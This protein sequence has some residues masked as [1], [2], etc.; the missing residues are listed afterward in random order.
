MKIQCQ[1]CESKFGIPP[2]FYGKRI[3]CPKCKG[4]IS[5]PQPTTPEAAKPSSPAPDH[6]LSTAKQ[7]ADAVAGAQNR[8]AENATG[9]DSPT[10]IT[11]ASKKIKIPCG[12][13]SASLNVPPKLLGKRVACP[14]CKQPVD[15]VAPLD[16]KPA[17]DS[18]PPIESSATA[19]NRAND[20][21]PTGEQEDAAPLQPA[22]RPATEGADS[23]N[24]NEESRQQETDQAAPA[25]RRSE[26]PSGFVRKIMP[27]ISGMIVGVLALLLLFFLYLNFSGVP[28][29]TTA[30]N[31]PESQTN[32]KTSELNPTP[33]T[34]DSNAE[35]PDKAAKQKA[36]VAIAEVQSRKA[37]VPSLK[38]FTGETESVASKIK[39]LGFNLTAKSEYLE[40]SQFNGLPAPMH[41]RGKVFVSAKPSTNISVDDSEDR[42]SFFPQESYASALRLPEGIFLAPIDS[43]QFADFVSV[44]DGKVRYDVEHSRILRRGDFKA[45]SSP[46]RPDF[47]RVIADNKGQL[48]AQTKGVTLIWIDRNAEIHLL[49]NLDAVGYDEASTDVNFEIPN[50]STGGI[51]VDQAG[52]I[53][54]LVAKVENGI[55]TVTQISKLILNLRDSGE[56]V[57]D[58][59]NAPFSDD[60]AGKLSE[61]S[62]CLVQLICKRHHQGTHAAF[63][64]HMEV[65]QGTDRTSRQ[66][67]DD[68]YDINF[69]QS[70]R[71]DHFSIHEGK[72][73][74]LPGFLGLAGMTCIVDFPQDANKTQWRVERRLTL[75]PPGNERDLIRDISDTNELNHVTQKND[76]RIINESDTHLTIER[77]YVAKSVLSEPKEDSLQW[78]I[79]A[80]FPF[81]VEGKFTYQYDKSLKMATSVVFE[82]VEHKNL[83]QDV[84]APQS[85]SFKMTAMPP[86]EIDESKLPWKADQVR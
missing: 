16:T 46:R 39:S 37:L 51:I 25:R 75:G 4:P 48:S 33:N 38:R 62:A 12:E 43:I 60:K 10:E 78:D 36:P 31:Q 15:L 17:V 70:G 14:N 54:G 6:P 50:D 41:Y 80:G 85:L 49:E 5:V 57:F 67:F 19:T 61:A 22:L 11:P 72:G 30:E 18:E 2:K 77:K 24:E 42:Q 27:L 63:N 13:C 58:F 3:K 55:G 23:S 81:H 20:E 74:R 7:P 56:E 40:D 32:S 35:G 76:Y 9:P 53:A 47:P 45:F 28:E 84:V 66:T 68:Q 69:R 44:F 71:I 34:N 79:P 83:A 82:G 64:S 59:Y 29:D 8:P 26:P 1:Q 73:C 65:Q 52:K 21:P 86:E